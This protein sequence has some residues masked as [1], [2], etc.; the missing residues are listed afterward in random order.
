MSFKLKIPYTNFSYR[1]Y[2]ISISYNFDKEIQ[3]WFSKQIFRILSCID[4]RFTN[5]FIN[6]SIQGHST[7]CMKTIYIK[8]VMKID[9]I[10]FWQFHKFLKGLRDNTMIQSKFIINSWVNS[11]I[12]ML[13][14]Q[15]AFLVIQ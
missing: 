8:Y 5:D 7:N 11:K 14:E 12:N 2:Y 9:L 4:E 15:Q 1:I 3:T 6:A 13:S 10:F